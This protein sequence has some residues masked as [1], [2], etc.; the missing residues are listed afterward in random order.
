MLHMVCTRIS[1]MRKDW[2][3]LSNV[4]K[5]AALGYVAVILAI[6]C[7][8]LAMSAVVALVR[9]VLGIGA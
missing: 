3:R 6:A 8:L 7:F 9:L 2:E 1:A 4:A 5:D